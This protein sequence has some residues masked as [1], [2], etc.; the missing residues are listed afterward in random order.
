MFSLQDSTGLH[1]GLRAKRRADLP[2]LMLHPYGT[3]NRRATISLA[4]L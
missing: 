2:V 1:G 4:N 3:E